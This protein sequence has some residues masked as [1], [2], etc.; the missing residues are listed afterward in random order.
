MIGCVGF[1]RE[2][3]VRKPSMF[4]GTAPSGRSSRSTHRPRPSIE[5]LNL[6]ADGAL[7]DA[8]QRHDGQMLSSGAALDAKIDDG[9]GLPSNERVRRSAG[10]STR[11][12]L[13]GLESRPPTGRERAEVDLL[14]RTSPESRVRP[15]GVVPG[16]VVVEF[17]SE[18]SFR[19]GHDGQE[20]RAF[21][22]HRPDEALDD[23][24]A[25]VSA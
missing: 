2:T 11:P 8:S 7:R 15:V 4:A 23:S 3:D 13:S 21:V 24:D 20:A 16:D 17:A 6:S 19:Q 18:R 12:S 5:I 25:S 22:L 9:T 14:G 1:E 10:R